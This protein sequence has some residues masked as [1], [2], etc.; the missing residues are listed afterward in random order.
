MLNPTNKQSTDIIVSI[1]HSY[2]FALLCEYTSSIIP[3]E[4]N[5]IQRVFDIEIDKR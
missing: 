5:N 2:S 4:G 1:G 3:I